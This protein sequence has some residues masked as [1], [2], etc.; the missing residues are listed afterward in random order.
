MQ[1]TAELETLASELERKGPEATVRWALDRFEK[2]AL[3]S[4]F[5]LEDVCLVHMAATYRKDARIFY[6]DTDVLF[7]ET[8]DVRDRLMDTYKIEFIRVEASIPLETQAKEYGDALWSRNPDLCCRLR[9]VIPLQNFLKNEDAW[10]TGIRREQTPA[11]ANAKVVEYDEKFGLVKVN[12]LAPWTSEDV[13]AYV[14]R[15]HIPYNPLHDKGY[16]SIGCVPCTRSVK[17]GEDPRAG[18]WAG[19]DKTECGLHQ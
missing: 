2:V 12:P 15:H 6:L 7:P 1:D 19:T 8:Y 17:P 9:K 11:R 16:P 10:V 4:S 13:R 3:A 14:D 5:G 18:R